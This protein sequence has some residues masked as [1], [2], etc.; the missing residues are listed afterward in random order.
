M[1]RIMKDIENITSGRSFGSYMYSFDSVRTPSPDYDDDRE[2]FEDWTRDGETTPIN[3]AKDLRDYTS[4][5]ARVR[6]TPCLQ[7]FLDG[8]RHAYHV[9]DIS[10]E[11]RVFPV[12]AGQI[13]VDCCQ[14]IDGRMQSEI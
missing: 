8:S 13:G 5:L 1:N 12:V 6:P 2:G 4:T 11:S 10:Y 3:G 9:D 7:Y 14:R